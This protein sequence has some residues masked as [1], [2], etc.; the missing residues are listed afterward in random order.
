MP[1]GDGTRSG[2]APLLV[3]CG[4]VFFRYRNG[5]IPLVLVPLFLAC[6]PR[7]A[8][9]DARLDAWMDGLGLAVAVLGQSLRAA[10]IG[11]A[12]IK[13]GGKGGRVYAAKLVTEGFFRHSRNPLYLGNLLVLSGLFIIH[14][15][16]WVYL[17]GGSFVLF[18]YRAIVAA[19]E[20]YL[21]AR[22][23]AEYE[24]YCRRVRRWLPDFRGLGRSLDGYRF[25]WR[26]LLVKEYG[27][28][29]VWTAAALLLLAYEVLTRSD[30]RQEARH[31]AM[32][33]L[34]LAFATAGWAAAR[35]VKK[36]TLLR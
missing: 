15:N 4:E 31:L 6:L 36:G 9:G 35:Y 21:R 32:L 30:Y 18:A 20:T 26:R 24:D 2:K 16:P 5:L 11:Y 12:Y 23:G 3:A 10:V 1:A 25:D 34:L 17:L 14:N 33:A 7:P 29:Y 22:F 8:F 19:E 27:T 13:R 28:A